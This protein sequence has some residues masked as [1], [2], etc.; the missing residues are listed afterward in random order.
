M[1][2][3]QGLKSSFLAGLT[4]VASG[5]GLP[6]AQAQ[7]PEP[8]IPQ[9]QTSQPDVLQ[10]LDA[11]EAELAQL[12]QQ[13]A[14]TG[15][16]NPFHYPPPPMAEGE[17]YTS[18]YFA[19]AAP[20]A[21]TPATTAAAK[22]PDPPKFPSVQVNGVFQADAGVFNQD[23]A[24]KALTANP[25]VSDGNIQNGA[26][27]RRARLSAKGSV[28]SNTN[29]F[30][31]MDFAFFG[32]P[33][34]TDVW[35][36]QT[37]LPLFGNVRV[38]QW[39]QPFSLEVV[40]SFRYTTFMERSLLFQTF[41]PFRHLGIGF[42]DTN[43]EKTT[44]WAA[45][46]IRT[47]QDQYGS[48]LSTDGGNGFV[49]RLTHVFGY[50]EACGGDEYLHTGFGYYANAGPR[51]TARFRTVPEVFIGEVAPGPLG[52]SR[53]PAPGGTQ[54][55]TPFLVDTGVLDA[56][57]VHTIGTELLLVKG[58]FSV[59][60]EMMGAFVN[61]NNGTTAFLNGAYLQ[62]GYFLTGEHRPY[63]RKSGAIDRVKP[64]HDFIWH[65]DSQL[66]GWGAWEVA[67]RWSYVDLNSGSVT[68][69]VQNDATFGINWYMNP[70]TKTTFNYIH[71]WVDRPLPGLTPRS[72]LN[73]FA[74]MV[75]L[76]F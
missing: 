34:F 74:A 68:G 58:P 17:Q 37:D 76:D 33:T 39:K 12:R 13:Q 18:S 19:P 30:F 63:D 50:D 43:E 41:T 31:Q 23:T 2:W 38:G 22:K 40:S 59:Q 60:S 27:F 14:L 15:P 75:Q 71:A 36:E 52:S 49:G 55:G 62:T 66:Q 29:Y 51:D 10:R 11:L 16:V 45:S 24:S 67:G 3:K 25:A 28:T 5:W 53:Q 4:L 54:N 26:A 8:P 7:L 64:K 21:N 6:E 65:K 61:L 47:G 48:S 1:R 32:R 69:G 9:V 20:P 35:V 44:T 72:E 73:A 57:V 46:L 56:S 42:Y 70:Y